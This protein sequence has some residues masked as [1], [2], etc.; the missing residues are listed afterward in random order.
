M[1]LA[2]RVGLA[3]PLRGLRGLLALAGGAVDV[4]SIESDL[5]AGRRVIQICFFPVIDRSFHFLKVIG[6]IYKIYQ[7]ASE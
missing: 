6:H 1:L 4:Y 5:A 7:A 2:E 3:G